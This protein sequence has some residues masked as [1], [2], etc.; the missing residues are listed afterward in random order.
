MKALSMT[1]PFGTLAVLGEKIWETRPR[2]FNHY[3][4]TAIHASKGFP[5]SLLKS[6][7]GGL[8]M[9]CNLPYFK[10]ALTKWGYD[11]PEMLPVS[12]I[13]GVVDIVRYERTEDIRDSLSEKAL[14]FGV[15]TDGRW[16][17]EFA[18]P[19]HI[20]PI[21]CRGYQGLW[22]VPHEIESKI[23]KAIERYS[24]QSVA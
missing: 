6:F 12:A 19:R 8:E 5:K 2:K 10:E 15:F 18:N 21:P 11:S 14:A 4:T 20:E 16:A 3:G 13:I 1:R 7:P 17:Y 24:V 22:N 9:V 23:V